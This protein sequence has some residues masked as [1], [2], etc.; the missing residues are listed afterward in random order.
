M[1]PVWPTDLP[2][3][4]RDY[5]AQVID[6]RRKRSTDAGVSG[7]GRKFSLAGK[8]VSL[9]LILS[10]SQKQVFDRFYEQDLDFGTRTF[11]MPDPVSD[12]WPLVTAEGEALLA[13]DGQQLLMSAQWLC[14]MGD[15][16]PVE[17]P[18]KGLLFPVS[19]SVV[20]MP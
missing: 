7:Y 5:Q 12:G 14:L 2:K 10:R 13:P 1:I 20:V 8:K 17:G 4:T 3:P 9:S 6:P 15:E 16:P 18:L 11:W 19:F